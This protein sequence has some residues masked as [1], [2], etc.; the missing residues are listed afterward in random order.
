[1]PRSTKTCFTPWACT[2]TTHSRPPRNCGPH[3]AR[4]GTGNQTGGHWR[5]RTGFFPQPFA[6]G[7]AGRGLRP[8]DRTGQRALA[9]PLV[10]HNRDAHDLTIIEML[11]GHGAEQVGGV[12]HC[13]SGDWEVARRVLDLGFH[14]GVTGIVTFPKSDDLREVVKKA[15]LDRLLVETDCPFLAPV[16][17]RGK[18]NQPAYVVHTAKAAA[19][20]RGMDFEEF[21]GATTGN[22]R[23][24]FGP[25]GRGGIGRVQALFPGQRT[26]PGLGLPPSKGNAGPGGPGVF[27]MEPAEVDESLQ[28][29]EQAGTGSA[30]R[31]AG[32]EGRRSGSAGTA[33]ESLGAGG[34]HSGGAAAVTI[35]GKP[36][37]EKPTPWP[38]WKCLNGAEHQVVTGYCLAGERYP[39]APAWPR[40][41]G[42]VPRI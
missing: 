33:P 31:L 3:S 16:P 1:M 19:E 11:K 13:F 28:P 17:F 25:A 41:H 42:P 26:D 35:L 39:G 21:A 10:I 27:G 32:S 36:R 5:M 9:I 6:K 34:R 20:C 24:L 23:R 14:L 40:Q 30:E 15:P 29:G 12:V 37:D 8:P 4:S 7:T 2:P 38:C 22:C 18:D